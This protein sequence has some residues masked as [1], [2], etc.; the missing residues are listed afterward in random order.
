MQPIVL[1]PFNLRIEYPHID[2][3]DWKYYNNNLKDVNATLDGILN[4][5]DLR[6]IYYR[7]KSNKSIITDTKSYFYTNKLK[8]FY[9]YLLHVYDPFKYNEY[10]NKL[11]ELHTQN[12][13][14]DEL[15]NK[16]V[17]TKEKKESNNTRKRKSKNRYYREVKV[18]M[19]TG[20]EMYTYYN[21]VTKDEIISEDPDMLKDLN[22]KPT[23]APRAST[24]AKE[25]TATT[26]A[27]VKP[28]GKVPLSHMTF[29]FA[30]KK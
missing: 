3:I 23:R 25:S 22:A 21:P 14:Y 28:G 18:D 8:Q 5:I 10:L 20:K 24:K 27:K 15:I 4:D 11:I 30:K 17:N 6:K 9:Y 13:E 1:N 16:K 12:L 19:F 2:Y 29:S 7:Q 26:V